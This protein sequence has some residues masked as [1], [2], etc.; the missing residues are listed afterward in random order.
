MYKALI[1]AYYY[2]PMGLSG[3]Q[4]ILKFTKYMPKFN[5]QPVVITTGN[6][7]YYAH[8]IS[9]LK[10]AENAGVQIIRTE[11]FDVNSI[12]GKKIQTVNIP[13]EFIR[14]NSF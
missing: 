5:W 10:E 11:A 13:K 12:I 14:K 6:V 9:L 7:A 3:V 4:R 8:D 1:L 2:P